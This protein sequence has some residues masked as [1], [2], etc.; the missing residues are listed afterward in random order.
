MCEGGKKENPCIYDSFLFFPLQTKQDPSN[1]QRV[2]QG[3]THIQ[4]YTDAITTGGKEEEEEEEN[5]F[6]LEKGKR[7]EGWRQNVSLA[8]AAAAV[9]KRVDARQLQAAGGCQ[10]A[11]SISDRRRCL[12]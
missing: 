5:T 2:T 6:I 8:A 4:S 1:Q 7:G 10:S 9:T 11:R 12:V 3:D